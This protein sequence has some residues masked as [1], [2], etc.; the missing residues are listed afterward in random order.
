MFDDK[1]RSFNKI[2]G[3]DP[4]I[5]RYLVNNMGFCGYLKQGGNEL[6]ILQNQ[7]S[8]VGETVTVDVVKFDYRLRISKL[9]PTKVELEFI[10]RAAK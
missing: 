7:V 3:L 1:S 2:S 10:D 9:N 8:A 6:A 5:S 4:T